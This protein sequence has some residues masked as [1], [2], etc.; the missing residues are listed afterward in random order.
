MFQVCQYIGEMCRYVLAVAPKP[1]DKNHKLRIAYGNGLRPQ[2]WSE[3][4]ERFNIGKIAEFY[5]ATEGNAN[6]SKLLIII[7]YFLL[8]LYLQ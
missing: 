1:D 2:I 8:I 4:R 6:I 5:G 7:T 3:F